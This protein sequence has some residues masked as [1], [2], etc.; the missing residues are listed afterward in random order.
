MF[1]NAV[2][3]AKI[4]AQGHWFQSSRGSQASV[5]SGDAGEERAGIH[6]VDI[7][8]FSEVMGLR[9]AQGC[10]ETMDGLRVWE[11]TSTPR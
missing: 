6:A 8:G 11:T 9:V 7:Y 10:V 2:Q 1:A 3:P 5:T 4:K